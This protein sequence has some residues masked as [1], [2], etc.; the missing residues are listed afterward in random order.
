MS[1]ALEWLA[2]V[3]VVLPCAEPKADGPEIIYQF[4]VVEAHGLQWREAAAAVS[5]QWPAAAE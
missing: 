5:S 2:M 1:I 3:L 4:Q